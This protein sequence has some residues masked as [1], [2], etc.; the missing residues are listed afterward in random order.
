MFQITPEG[1]TLGNVKTMMDAKMKG[2]VMA[3]MAGLC[4]VLG[5]IAALGSTW[6]VPTGDDA[7]EL[8]DMVVMQLTVP[9]HHLGRSTTEQVCAEADVKR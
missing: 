3:A 1:K 5:I 6:L 9:I 2:M 4:L 8:E 7:E